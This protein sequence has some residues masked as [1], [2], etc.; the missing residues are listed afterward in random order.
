MLDIW[1]ALPLFILDARYYPP[2]KGVD[3]T[4]AALRQRH[5]VCKIKFCVESSSHFENVWAAMQE[6]F[7]ELSDITLMALCIDTGIPDSFLG[8]TAPGLRCLKLDGVPF[9]GLPKL[10]LST[11][12]LVTLCL[13]RIPHSEYT[14]PEVMVNCLS[15]LTNLETLAFE[16]EHRNPE[17]RR[18]PPPMRS[19]LPAL[20]NF[21]FKGPIDY[22]E[23]FVACVNALRL[24]HLSITFLYP[25]RMIF[26]TPYHVQFIGRTPSLEAP[27]KARIT[28]GDKTVRVRLS[29]Q[30]FGNGV[31][32]VGISWWPISMDERFSCLAQICSSSFSAVENLSIIDD[33]D[34][35]DCSQANIEDR[36]WLDLLRPFAS[37]KNLCIHRETLPR[38]APTLQK[39]VGD[40]TTEVLPILPNLFTGS[41]QPSGLVQEGIEQFAVARRLFG[42]PITVSLWDRDSE[43]EGVT[44]NRII[45]SKSPPLSI[46]LSH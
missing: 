19:V 32:D 45:S 35:E 10:L 43:Q 27:E 29:S 36:L 1:P 42:H 13:Q 12:H 44:H 23:D 20:T 17:S 41:R 40:R 3:N 30:T 18:Q 38:I 34:L 37:V 4:I 25:Y 11:T 22:W 26:D 31:L 21:E 28:F 5:R 33:R 2:R 14:S 46:V 24:F 39:L 8:G 15:A 7:P 6:P 9:P 16:F